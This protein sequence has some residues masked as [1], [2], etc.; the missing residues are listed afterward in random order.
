LNNEY[1]IVK[2][3]SKESMEKHRQKYSFIYIG[4]VQVAVKQLTRKGLNTSVLLCLRDERHFNFQD[5]L[6]GMG[7]SSL[8]E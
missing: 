3:F 1:E 5:S 4:L 7:E 6:L 2:L 8:Y